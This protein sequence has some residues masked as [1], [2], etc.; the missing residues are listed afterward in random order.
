MGHLGTL[1]PIAT[2]VLPILIGRATRLAQFY[3]RSEKVYE[4][5][6]RFGFSTDTYDREGCATSPETAV[7]LDAALLEQQLER[8]R[9]P[10]LQAPPPVSAKKVAGERA[11]RLARRHE[12]FQLEPVPVH[13]YELSILEIAGCEARLRARCSAGTYMRSIAH[14]LGQAL[15]CGAH[16]HAL[17]RIASGEFEVGQAHTITDLEESAAEGT[18]DQALIPSAQ[19]LPQLTSA[20]VDASAA[21]EIRHGRDFLISPF[22]AQQASNYVKA[23]SPEGEL[24]AIGEARLPNS[25]HPIVVL[26]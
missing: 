24:L 5:V 13:V 19:L 17:Q 14:D 11:Y 2:G 8:F 9:G 3:S 15:R 4:A 23:I 22:R 6:V 26:Y 1:D 18:L 12:T 10:F 21:E 25:Y 20:Y 7:T 16:L